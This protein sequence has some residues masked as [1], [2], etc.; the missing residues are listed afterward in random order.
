MSNTRGF[1]IENGVL[2]MYVG[3]G[4]DVVVP[5]DVTSIG[6]HAFSGRTKLISIVLPDGVTSI[7]EWAFSGCTNLTSIVLP[8]GVTSIHG[9]AFS[10]CI[11]LTIHAPAGSYAETYAKKNNIPFVAE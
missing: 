7:G 4:G 8:E 11:K 3:P 2:K 6:D 9:V 10:G 1:V 5:K